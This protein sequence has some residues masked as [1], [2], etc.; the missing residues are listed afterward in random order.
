MS[1]CRLTGATT[2]GRIRSV[3]RPSPANDDRAGR[4]RGDDKRA[5][6]RR[7]LAVPTAHHLLGSLT[8]HASWP[9][10]RTGAKSPVPPPVSWRTPTTGAPNP[11]GTCATRCASWRRSPA[12]QAISSPDGRTATIAASYD[13]AIGH[14]QKPQVSHAPAGQSTAR[15][16]C[17]VLSPGPRPALVDLIAN[18]PALHEGRL[19]VS[20]PTRLR[21]GPGPEPHQQVPPGHGR[22]PF[23]PLTQPSCQPSVSDPSITK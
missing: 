20:E 9:A 12:R 10:T 3:S 18:R 16:L 5:G 7:Q 1:R 6:H 2:I 8:A 11:R 19:T 17:K 23:C 15:H 13:V 4:G 22:G 21:L 14:H